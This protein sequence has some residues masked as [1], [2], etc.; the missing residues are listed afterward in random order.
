MQKILVLTDFSDLSKVA[1]RYAV[2]VSNLLDCELTLLNL[3]SIIQ[4]TRVSL[5]LKVK[6]LEE[7]MV[8][9]AK[10]DMQ[11]LISEIKELKE[12]KYPVQFRVEK[13]QYLSD[14]ASSV[15][16]SLGTRLIVMGTKG[17]SGLKKYVMGTNAT[18]VI[19]TSDVPVLAVP[20]DAKFTGIRNVVYASSTQ[21]LEDELGLVIYYVKGFDANLHVFHVADEQHDEQRVEGMIR[22]SVKGL[23]PAKVVVKVV[24]DGRIEKEIDDYVAKSGAEL[25]AM[26][27]HRPTFYEKLFNRSITRQV[28]FQNHVPLLAFKQ[29]LLDQKTPAGLMKS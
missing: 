25:L 18:S 12:A 8:S 6:V 26:F 28:A 9:F 10:E 3:V 13:G 4:P 14:I 11:Q 1:I 19:A 23:D 24:S 29:Q 27:T 20:A 21:S 22:N 5:Q 7:E 15:S 2:K 17:A 16:N